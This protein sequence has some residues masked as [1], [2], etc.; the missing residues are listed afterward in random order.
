MIFGRDGCIN[1]VMCM[2]LLEWQGREV[3]FYVSLLASKLTM[4][5]SLGTP[6]LAC[7]QECTSHAT[8][9]HGDATSA[10]STFFLFLLLSL[11]NI[12]AIEKWC[13]RCV[14]S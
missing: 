3:L 13:F 2:L 5:L 8:P 1:A 7:L 6:T 12:V 4:R 10:F 14:P 11:F 9:S